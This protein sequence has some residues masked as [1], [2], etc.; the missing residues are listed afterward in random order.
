MGLRRQS[1]E[2][3]EA[4]RCSLRRHDKYCAVKLAW[5]KVRLHVRK[6]DAAKPVAHAAQLAPH[7][8][9]SRGKNTVNARRSADCKLKC[10]NWLSQ[11]D[12]PDRQW[13]SENRNTS[14]PQRSDQPRQICDRHWLGQH[15]SGEGIA[16]N[17]QR[18]QVYQISRQGE[19]REL[20]RGQVNR[21]QIC[22]PRRE[23]EVR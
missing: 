5:R 4:V 15:K 22:Q 12:E 7:I 1:V 11:P 2:L 16:V 20:I 14:I 13:I 8:Q 19:F 9:I 17:E 3:R 18:R 21:A 6:N 10:S 23:R